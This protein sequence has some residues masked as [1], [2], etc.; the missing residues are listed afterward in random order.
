MVWVESE[1][2]GLLVTYPQ[3]TTGS[4]WSVPIPAD[5]II[6]PIILYWWN[7]ALCSL[8]FNYFFLQHS[9][10]D[11]IFVWIDGSFFH[12]WVLHKWLRV[13]MDTSGF[14]YSVPFYGHL[15][16]L[17]LWLLFTKLLSKDTLTTLQRH[18]FSCFLWGKWLYY[19]VTVCLRFGK[20]PLIFQR[21]CSVCILTD[22]LWG[23]GLLEL[24]SYLRGQPVI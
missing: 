5:Q 11:F 21:G 7:H 19:I 20:L 15:S 23:P 8:L 14:A 13:Q 17:I 1:L 18:I 16:F 2:L 10:S 4:L 12:G 22:I 9:Y 3:T 24:H 6:P